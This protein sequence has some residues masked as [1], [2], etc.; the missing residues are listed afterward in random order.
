MNSYAQWGAL[1]RDMRRPA[2]ARAAF[3][4]GM[5]LAREGDPGAMAA[6]DGV[7]AIAELER[8]SKS[9]PAPPKPADIKK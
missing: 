6:P 7:T 8:E 9:P 4:G 3:A 5:K 2:E 1:L